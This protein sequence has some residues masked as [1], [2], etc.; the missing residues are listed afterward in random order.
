MIGDIGMQEL[1]VI[2]L[3][4]LLLFGADRIPALA[5]GLGKGVRE[6]KRVVNNA[7][8]EI[9]RAMDID[10]QEQP[11]RRPPPSKELDRS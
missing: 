11:P 9:Q 7:N 2:F 8:T 4:V 1:M 5:R 6:F 3:I 10:E